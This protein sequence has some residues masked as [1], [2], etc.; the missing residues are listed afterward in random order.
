MGSNPLKHV[1]V[2][3]WVR[4]EERSSPTCLYIM[5][6][7]GTQ[8]SFV[9]DIPACGPDTDPLGAAEVQASAWP[10]APSGALAATGRSPPEGMASSKATPPPA[11][12]LL[13]GKL[14]PKL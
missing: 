6:S 12:N 2:T 10:P 7:D 14:M 9:S 8:V 11:T 5:T 4:A 13:A 1:V 3:Q